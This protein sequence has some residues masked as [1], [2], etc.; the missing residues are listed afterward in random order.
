MTQG[1]QL[2]HLCVGY[3]EPL[4]TADLAIPQGSL[5]AILGPSGSGKST[6][7]ASVLGSIPALSGRVIVD[8]HDITAMPTHE[9]RIGMVFQDPLLFAHLTVVQNVMYGLQRA[10][11]ARA[12]AR[13]RA[14]ELLDWVGMAGYEARSVLELSGGQAQRVALVR[15]LAPEPR[16]LLLD[17]PYSALDADLRSRLAAE[18][19]A[20]LRERQVTAIHVTHDVDEAMSITPDVYRVL[21][22]TLVRSAM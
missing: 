17:E 13:A 7:L 11:M 2:E 5:I 18:V 15:A 14:V 21:D 4:L 20:L 8:G 3:D 22:G 10:G 1:L 19:A 12:A 6:L 16:A 9:R